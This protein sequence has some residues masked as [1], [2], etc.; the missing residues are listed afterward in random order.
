MGGV[1]FAKDATLDIMVGGEAALIERVR[2]LLQAIGRNVIHCGGTGTAHALKALANYVNACALINAIEAMTIG[3]R[4]G[5]DSKLMAQA[6]T[7]MCAGRNHPVEK[8]VVPHVL[9]RK[10]GT[11]MAMGFI[12][13]DVR[14]AME[15]ARSAGAFA[16]LGERVSELWSAAAEKL[17]AG[18]DQTEI[19][20]YWEDATG[21]RL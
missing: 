1:V 6:L 10:Y 21:V 17:G 8:K 5:L 12:A 9:T 19:A 2:P 3:R 16:P 18:L 14:I 13:K 15:T 20:R 4:F 11:G 7:T